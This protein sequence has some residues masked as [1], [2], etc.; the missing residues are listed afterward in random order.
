MKTMRQSMMKR[1]CRRAAGAPLFAAIALAAAAPA[2]AQ[3]TAG[4]LRVGLYGFGAVLRHEADF[5]TLPGVTCC[6]PGFGSGS[7]AGYGVGFLLQS[8]ILSQIAVQLRAGYSFIGGELTRSEHIGNALAGEA[9]VVDAYSEH[10]IAPRL[11]MLSVEPRLSIRPFDLPL[12]ID[13]GYELGWVAQRE[14][15][16]QETLTAPGD[17]TFLDGT[18]VRNR[19][20]GEIP[21]A[22]PLYMAATGGLSYDIMIG[23]RLVVSPEISYRQQLNDVLADSA[24]KANALRVGA[25]VALRLAPRPPQ[26]PDARGVLT[27]TINAMGVQSD[28]TESPIVQMRVE[29]F[30]S[31]RLRPLL[32]Y[33]FFD[34]DSSE[35]PSR[36]DRLDRS[37]TSTFAIDRLHDRDVMQTYRD[38]LNIIGR[39]MLDDPTATIR[40]IGCNADDG[41]EKGNTELSRRRAERVRDYLRDTW[42]IPERRMRIEARNLPSVPSNAADADGIAENRR[43]E[44]VADHRSIT[45]PVV[46]ADT[47]RVSDPPTIRFRAHAGSDAGVASWSLV[48]MQ[49]G[50]VLRELGGRGDV[51]PVI[52]WSLADDRASMPRDAEPLDFRLDVVDNDGRT[53]S[54]PLASIAVEQMTLRRKRA[55]RIADREIDRYSL[56]LFDFGSAELDDAN[57][58]IADLIRSRITRGST[59]E[60]VGHTDR[61]G[62]EELNRK[63]SRDRAMNVAHTLGVGHENA[64]GLGESAM[65]DN[66]LPEGRF[67]CRIVDVTV[68]TPVQ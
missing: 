19:R 17:A 67:Y 14:Y 12:A 42:S 53:I 43:V 11:G 31:T 40:I 39:R 60:I 51:P 52:D 62:D 33:V 2:V 25:S 66:D 4:D 48:A 46:T 35:L 63:L 18:R 29:E 27:A 22:S 44:I 7:G 10:R 32:N 49:G 68:E 65:F 30:M 26:T 58:S 9:T 45:A 56:I 55:E 6:G 59:V 54:T 1:V 20:S 41:I 57:R 47:L 50:R 23:R 37:A 36:Y 24:W 61:V 13:V 21:E 16:Q 34:D 64:R 15:E 28:G 5:R 3:S 38:V 8:P